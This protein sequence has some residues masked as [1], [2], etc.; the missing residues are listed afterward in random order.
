M[1]N[2]SKLKSMLGFASKAGDLI[3]GTA[4]VENAI[5]KR[6]AFLVICAQDLSAKTIKNFQYYCQVNG[7]KFYCYGTR[8]VLGNWIGLPERGI[9]GITSHK[10]ALS[11]QRLFTDRGESP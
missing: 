5:K 1:N 10:F 8:E 7:V 9:I 11:I 4:A 2:E 6:K 3:A